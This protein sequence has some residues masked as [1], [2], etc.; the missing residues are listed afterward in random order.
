MNIWCREAAPI[1]AKTNNH[2]GTNLTSKPT[3]CQA[4]CAVLNQP[5]PTNHDGAWGSHLCTL[6]LPANPVPAQPSHWSDNQHDGHSAAAGVHGDGRRTSSC[7]LSLSACPTSYPTTWGAAG[8]AADDCAATRGA[9]HADPCANA[10]ARGSRSAK[11]ARCARDARGARCCRRPADNDGAGAAASAGTARVAGCT[12]PGEAD[13]SPGER[14]LI[15]SLTL[16]KMSPQGKM[17]MQQINTPTGPKFIA[18]PLGQTL[19]QGQVRIVYCATVG[20]Q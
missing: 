2:S 19:M 3:S 11:C 13:H 1:A 12:A 9:K 18:V 10:C 4:G 6:H 8:S 14:R 20:M 7:I 16:T 17:T 5:R 15:F